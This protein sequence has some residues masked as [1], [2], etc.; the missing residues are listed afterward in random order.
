SRLFRQKTPD[1]KKS[2]T[3][4][5]YHLNKIKWQDIQDQKQK[6]QENSDNQYLVT[7]KASKRKNTLRECTAR[8]KEEGKNL[9][10]QFSWKKNK[11]QN[12]L[13]VSLSASLQICTKK[14]TQNR[15]LQVRFC[16]NYANPV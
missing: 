14:Q 7:I 5:V 11:K 12:I 8:T 4:N 2:L 9:N 1:T 3:S 13:T 10:T 15:E 6:S 16:Y